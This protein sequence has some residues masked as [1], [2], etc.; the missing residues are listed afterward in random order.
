MHPTVHYSTQTL[1]TDD[2]DKDDSN[3][4]CQDELHATLLPPGL[5]L[6]FS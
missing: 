5:L 3:D 4:G 2:D 6:K 1:L